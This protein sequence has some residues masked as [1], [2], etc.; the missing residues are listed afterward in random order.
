MKEKDVLMSQFQTL[1]A[2]IIATKARLYWTVALGLF[3]VP[4]LTYLASDA[5]RYVWLLV[6]YSVLILLVVFVSEQNA[7]MRAGRY[8]RE[9]IEPHADEFGWEGWLEEHAEA[10]IMERHFV[11]CF[12]VIFFIYYVMTVAMAVQR[13]LNDAA[14]DPSG[15]HMYWLAAA[16]ITY[17]IGALWAVSTLV[18]HWR[19]TVSTSGSSS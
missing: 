16:A 9:R 14:R 7:M 2:E 17:V 5:E 4:T 11:A 6:P 10:R 1:R 15:Q 13:L 8:I 12:I 19:S 18:H 3:G